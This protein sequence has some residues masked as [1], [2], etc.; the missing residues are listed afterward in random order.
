M[1]PTLYWTLLALTC[2]YAFTRGR[3]DERIV[4]G[5]CLVASLITPMVLPSVAERYD[6]VET[7]ELLV[8]LAVLLIFV[9]VALRSSRFWPL[10]V[11]GLQLTTSLAHGLKAIELDLLSNAY[12][13]AGRSWSYLILLILVV[14]TWR[15]R[16][17]D[18]DPLHRSTG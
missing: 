11:A 16:K 14:A 4:A 18:D 10:W 7:G 9:G 12:A 3:S 13:A 17:R 5:V 1:N 2:G 8:D 6:R 15:S